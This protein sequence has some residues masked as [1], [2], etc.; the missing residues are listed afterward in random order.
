MRVEILDVGHGQCIYVVADNGNVMLFD[1]GSDEY[2]QPSVYLPRHGCRGI[3]RFFVTNYDE[4]HISDLPA[5]RR[6]PIGI[7][8]RNTSVTAG[9][10]RELKRASGPITTAMETLLG[11]MSGYTSTVLNPPEFPGLT[12]SC[13]SNS[14]KQDFTDTNNLSLVT[15]LH[16]RGIHL[17]IPGDLEAAGWR[18][19]LAQAGFRDEL[20][21]VNLFVASHHGRSSGYCPEVFELCR[22]EL[23]LISDEEM[24]YETQEMSSTYASHASGVSWSNQVRRVLTTRSD[25]SIAINQGPADANPIV[26]YANYRR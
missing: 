11:M 8:H 7:L 23:V 25:G 9:Q 26:A 20:R 1:C 3:E 14:F 4:D 5:L 19:L 10:L 2:L 22:P 21:K 24:Q 18:C 15:F 17:V 12:Y 6:L 16:Y 13:Y